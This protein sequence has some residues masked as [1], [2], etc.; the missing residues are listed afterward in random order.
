MHQ[1]TLAEVEARL[2]VVRRNMDGEGLDGL[3]VTE[4]TDVRYLCGYGHE[5]AWLLVTSQAQYLTARHRGIQRAE[6]ESTGF[7]MIDQKNSAD[8]VKDLVVAHDLKKIGVNGKMPANQLAGLRRRL[9][10]AELKLSMAVAGARAVKSPREIELLR[11]AQ[12]AAE[13]IFEAFL[14]EIKPGVTEYHLHNRLIQLIL[15]DESLDGPSFEPII[16]SGP[17][18]WTPHSYYTGRKLRQNDCLIVDMGVRY[19]GYCS[20]MTRTLFLG[21]PAGEMRE[22]YDTILEAQRRAIAEI[23]PWA[24]GED[25]AAAAWDFIREKGYEQS[26][27][28]GH[29]IGL[30]VHDYPTPGLAPANKKP[31]SEGN[32]FTVE[33]GTY[34][35]DKFGVRLEDV[36]IVTG[37]G[38]QNIT[39]TS[40]ELTIVG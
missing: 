4:P 27:G 2:A 18:S 17:S 26:H 5:G 13:Q 3:L 29:G 10:P 38:C 12:R 33:P 35:K 16:A 37:D 20:D 7:Q 34:L 15:D 39:S 24:M 11:A 22:V 32:V 21:E 25:V 8:V 31:L 6:R 19:Q 14:E 1:L 36:V 40:K 23:R 28:L 9:G 30:D